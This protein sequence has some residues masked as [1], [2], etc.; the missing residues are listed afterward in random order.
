MVKPLTIPTLSGT[1]WLSTVSGEGQVHRTP[2]GTFFV[3]VTLYFT[4]GQGSR[5]RAN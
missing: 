2:I 1:S 5:K 3:N 4:S